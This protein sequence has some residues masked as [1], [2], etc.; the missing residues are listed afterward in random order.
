MYIFFS[1][2]ILHTRRSR[3]SRGEGGRK[4]GGKNKHTRLRSPDEIELIEL[5]LSRPPMA[6]LT[7]RGDLSEDIV[8]SSFLS[9]SSEERGLVLVLDSNNHITEYYLGLEWFLSKL[10]LII[11]LG[12]LEV[13]KNFRE[14]RNGFNEGGR[15]HGMY[16]Y[17]I[18]FYSTPLHQ[19]LL[20]KSWWFIDLMA[21]LFFF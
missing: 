20:L 21:S 19:F 13:G 6:P 9:L 10:K 3:R 12:G 18:Y 4:E 2:K 7:P 14:L 1:D 11:F 8:F 15:G 16:T 17:N 5:R